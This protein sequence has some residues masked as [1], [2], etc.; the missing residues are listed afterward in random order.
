MLLVPFDLEIVDSNVKSRSVPLSLEPAESLLK[1]RTS[2]VCG[3]L[4][5]WSGTQSVHDDVMF[6]G[7]DSLRHATAN[8][9]VG[10]QGK[11]QPVSGS[12]YRSELLRFVD[13]EQAVSVHWLAS[14]KNQERTSSHLPPQEVATTVRRVGEQRPHEVVSRLSRSVASSVT[15]KKW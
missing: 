13:I 11:A 1:D 8:H 3:S 14:R 15:K 5:A 4:A 10:T 6:G 9:R 2:T 7:T 12:E